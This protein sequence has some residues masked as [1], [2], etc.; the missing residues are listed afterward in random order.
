M[1]TTDETGLGQ[2][3]GGLSPLVL[4]V[5]DFDDNR[6][7]FTEFL[8]FS[9]FRVAQASTGREALD[10][11]FSLLPDLILMDLSL[12][13]LDGLEATRCLKSDERTKRIPIVALT[14][15]ALAGHSKDA[16]EAGCDSFLTKPCLPDALVTEI[17]RVL[18]ARAR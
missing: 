2:Q 13:E 14:G 16:K 17:K 7:M 11:A 18:G 6:E 8:S 5:D 15:H 4:V 12:P 1:K 10:Q 3:H 9:G